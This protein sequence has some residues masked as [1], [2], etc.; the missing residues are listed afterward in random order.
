MAHVALLLLALPALALAEPTADVEAAL[1]A[2]DQCASGDAECALN[3][4]QLRGA[5]IN[6]T[7]LAALGIDAADLVE[8]SEESTGACDTGMVSKIKRFAPECFHACPQACPGLN[9]AL[10]AYLTRGGLPAARP[11]ICADYKHYG[12][13]LTSKNILKCQPLIHKAASFGVSL[14]DSWG[15]LKSWCR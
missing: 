11:V 13:A 4:L 2:D 12:C 3:A 1:A 14:P 6:A 9:N 10:M 15:G 5:G 8:I 7:E